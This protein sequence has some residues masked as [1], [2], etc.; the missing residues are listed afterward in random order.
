MRSSP[1]PSPSACF[2]PSTA[3]H[4]NRGAD[5]EEEDSYLDP[6]W[7]HLQLVCELLLRYVMSSNTET[8]VAKCYIDHSF[9]LCLHDLFDSED[10][11]EHEYLKTILHRIYGKKDFKLANTVIRGLL[12]FWPVT[13]CQKEVLFLGE[14]EEVLEVTQ[15][16]D[17]Q[18]C[19]VP[20]F[21]QIAHCLSSSHFQKRFNLEE[22]NKYNTSKK[23]DL[24]VESSGK[25]NP[26]TVANPSTVSSLKNTTIAYR[27]DEE[28]GNLAGRVDEEE[29]RR[30]LMKKRKSPLEPVCRI[31]AKK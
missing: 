10:P 2:A 26:S 12:K 22:E 20:L 28:E 31:V 3:S 16:A 25:H 4:E 19:I 14:L 13:N 30:T 1:P 29:N 17:F 5:L 6:T 9:V 11:H 8:K 23:E 27:V 15:P 24:T 21:K 18:R 7:L